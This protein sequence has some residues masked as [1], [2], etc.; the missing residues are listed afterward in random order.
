MEFIGDIPKFTTLLDSDDKTQLKHFMEKG[1][2][3]KFF[4][5]M[6]AAGAYSTFT[7]MER[8]GN[9]KV[10]DQLIEFVSTLTAFMRGVRVDPW[11]TFG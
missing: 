3:R 6:L 9:G 1:Q 8:E 10:E 5:N 2:S 11:E 4:L 7:S